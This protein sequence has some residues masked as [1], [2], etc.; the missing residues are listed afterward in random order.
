MTTDLPP[1]QAVE[2]PRASSSKKMDVVVEEATE[3]DLADLV[4]VLD[5]YPVFRVRGGLEKTLSLDSSVLG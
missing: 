3:K 1:A 2:A 5:N 4:S